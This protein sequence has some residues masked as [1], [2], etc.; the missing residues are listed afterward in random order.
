[1]HK[2]NN[3]EQIVTP[4]G[5]I[6]YLKPGQNIRIEVFKDSAPNPHYCIVSINPSG[7]ICT[8]TGQIIK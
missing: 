4:Y 2:L 8:S 1:M 7:T 5:S 3:P 6:A